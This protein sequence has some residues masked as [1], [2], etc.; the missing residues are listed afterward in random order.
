MLRKHVD[1][2]YKVDT[3]EFQLRFKGSDDIVSVSHVLGKF[4][5]ITEYDLHVGLTLKM[6]GRHIT[7]QQADRPTMVW[8]ESECRRLKKVRDR[9]ASELSKYEAAYIKLRDLYQVQELRARSGGSG[10]VPKAG[11]LPLRSYKREVKELFEHLR[12]IRP[13]LAER[14]ERE[15]GH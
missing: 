9:L 12:A 8:L 3:A 10:R 1:I 4:G 2:S 13:Q 6:L 11:A 7:L 5:P 14:L 15:L